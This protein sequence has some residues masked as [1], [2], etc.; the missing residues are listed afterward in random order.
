M[1]KPAGNEGVVCMRRSETRFTQK[2]KPMR[3][4][5]LRPT[6]AKDAGNFPLWL[7]PGQFRFLT[8]NADDNLIAYAKDIV[9]P[10]F[11]SGSEIT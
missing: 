1:A 2:Y 8:L 6:I 5:I 9:L 10:R 4:R 7:A 3:G 11:N